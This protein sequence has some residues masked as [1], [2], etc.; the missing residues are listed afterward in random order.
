MVDDCCPEQSGHWVASQCT[1]PRVRVLYHAEN[2][3]VG[4]AVMSGYRAAIEDGQDIVVKIDGDGQMDPALLPQFVAPLLAG[5]ADY[6][7]GN[8]FFHLDEI[9]QMPAIR[10]F[11]NAVLSF[12]SKVST[13]YWGLF[14][15]TNGYTAIQTRVASHLPMDQISKRYFFETDMLFRLN[16]LRAVVVDVPMDAFYGDEESNLKIT[17][18]LPEFLS[19]HIRNT[20]KRIF[21]NYYLRDLSLASFELPLGLCL[22]IFG[23]IFGA[24]R[25]WHVMETGVA[26][27]A[28][29]VMLSALPLILGVQFLLAFLGADIANQPQ[30]PVFRSFTIRKKPL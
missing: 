24:Y 8:R 13:G 20:F 16:T 22:S 12:M 29:T 11:G 26:A 14:D 15:P 23:L 17:K 1:D 19:K 28:G 2:Q 3:G 5:D 25:W 21:Y 18:V 10:L 9:H 27:T 7:K 30:K 4:G 6:A